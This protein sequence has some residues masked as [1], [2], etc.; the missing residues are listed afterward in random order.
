MHMKDDPLNRAWIELAQSNPDLLSSFRRV[1][2]AF[3]SSDANIKFGTAGTGFIVTDTHEWL[4]FVTA[5]HVLEGILK[6]QKPYTRFDDGPFQ[7]SSEIQNVMLHGKLKVSVFGDDEAFL[8]GVVYLSFNGVTDIAV[9]MAEIPQEF[10]FKRFWRHIPLA[11]VLPNVGDPIHICSLINKIPVEL[12]GSPRHFQLERGVTLRKGVVTNV[13]P[14]GFNQYKWPCFTTSI[15][16]IPGMSGGFAYS[17]VHNETIAACGVVCAELS[18][19]DPTSFLEPG[20]SLIACS[21]LALA[22]ILP[23]KIPRHDDSEFST[24]Y[25]MVMQKQFPKPL[26]DFDRVEF[27]KKSP[28]DIFMRIK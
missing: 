17:P 7:T 2:L 23:H 24:L 15:P 28:N 16:A 6:I 20:Q 21:F 19:S 9:G 13:H 14:S 10:R 5:K 3:H 25:E 1:L 11:V 22:N 4:C 26:G 18:D 27:V 12:G 8:A